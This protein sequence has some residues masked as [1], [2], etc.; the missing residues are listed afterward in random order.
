MHQP[1]EMIKFITQSSIG[2]R[3]VATLTGKSTRYNIG[4]KLT[5]KYIPKLRFYH[6]DT[7]KQAER[8][9]S[10]IDKLHEHD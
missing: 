3:P 2:M 5:L 4:V 10:L 8:I 6:D 9:D 1:I 7:Q